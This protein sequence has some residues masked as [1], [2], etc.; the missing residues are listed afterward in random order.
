MKL[1]R[2]DTR[3]YGKLF[4]HSKSNMEINYSVIPCLKTLSKLEE[5][6]EKPSIFLKNQMHDLSSVVY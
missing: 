4:F 1:F 6:K 5:N 3:H 2:V